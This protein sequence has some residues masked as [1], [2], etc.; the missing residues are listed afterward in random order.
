MFIS[1]Y[2]VLKFSF[3]DV[4]RNIW[5]SLVTVIILILALF[6]VNMLLIVKVIGDTAVDAIKEKIDINLFLNNDSEENEILALKAQI[7]GF[8]EVREVTYVSKSEALEKFKENHKD[9]PEILEAL[10]ELGKNPLTPTLV[11]KPNNLDEFDMLINRIN[12]IDSDMIESRN[13]TN[14]KVLLDKIN[15][16]TKK[17]TDAGLFLSSIFVFISILVV[18][19]SIRISIYTHKRE[20]AIMKLVGASNWFIQLPFLISGWFYTLIGV[21]FVMIVFYPFLTLLQPYL[22]AFFVG[23]N[24]DLVSYFYTNAFT[25]FGA[26][27]MVA[28][29]INMLA[30]L[31]AVRKY[32]KV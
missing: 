25:I 13:F 21:G 9:N 10:R 18:F 11:I 27:F 20:I 16:I 24:I 26:E 3:Q 23:Y 31:L 30:S 19:N 1:F 17:V 2:R 28:G 6:T 5:L 29:F 4:Y 14:Y 15:V 7:G 12:S 8:S 32:S 22:E